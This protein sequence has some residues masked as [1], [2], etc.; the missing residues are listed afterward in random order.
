[1][2]N[3][4]PKKK[5][6]PKLMQKP[7]S[8]GRLSLYLEY[9]LGYSKEYNNTTDKWQIKHK[10][11][12][13]GLE[14]YI[15]KKPRTAIENEHNR[16]TLQIADSIRQKREDT[17][18]SNKLNIEDKNKAKI[19]FIDYSEKFL[20]DYINKD[21]R[22][23]KY[24]VKY[25]N[26]FAIKETGKDYVLPV[27]VNE[28]FAK[29]FKN[30]L[31]SKL[32]GETPY[33]YFTKFKKICKEAF[34]EGLPIDRKILEIKNKRNEGLKKDILSFDEINQLASTP[35]NNEN[36]KRAFL[37]S[38]FTGLRFCDIKAL[39]WQ[40]I[41]DEH[42]IIKSQQK[43]GVSV[44]ID[45]ST[46]S[47]RLLGEKG[48]ANELVFKLPSLTSCLLQLKTWT[49]NAKIEKNI[50]WHSARHSFAV[51]LLTN[52]TDIKTVSSLLGHAGLKHT[53]K[54][55]RVISELKKRAANSLPEI[56]IC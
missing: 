51:N 38:L 21:K 3:L 45:L 29:K 10:R 34:N 25:L 50:T 5:D 9:Y 32:N 7:L 6:N 28:K 13:E 46:T 42:I 18:K 55:T 11:K 12:K 24:C 26:E 1:M 19:N 43:T 48:K 37:L 22:L 54:Y 27:E 49:K 52:Q 2:K 16:E 56:N 44:Y 36:V 4:H 31:E 15:Y 17:L 14:L 20:L 8:D 30:F 41:N 33:N 47:K 40:S 35:L 39:Q 53:E 23:V